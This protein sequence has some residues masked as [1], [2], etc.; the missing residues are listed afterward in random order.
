MRINKKIALFLAL[1]LFLVP[2]YSVTAQSSYFKFNSHNREEFRSLVKQSQENFSKYR[3]AQ[4]AFQEAKN[5]LR[6]MNT[7]RV[8]ALV[9]ERA[10]LFLENALNA[11]ILHLKA[12]KKR[13]EIAQKIK[14]EEKNRILSQIDEQINWF[15]N[16]KQEL[17]GLENREDIKKMAEEMKSYMNQNRVFMKKIIG[18]ILVARMNWVIEAFNEVADKLSAKITALENEGKDVTNLKS[19]LDEF[20][21]KIDEVSN[22]LEQAQNVFEKMEVGNDVKKLFGEGMSY[23]KEAHKGLVDAHKILVEIKVEMNKLSADNNQG[24]A[25]NTNQ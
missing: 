19:K 24:E 2:F 15:E 20:K 11:R 4:K 13:I 5:K 14:E 25:E 17:S 18:Q 1:I 6:E 23:L 7:E 12:L 3:E 22:K 8:Q 9:Q 10:K 21:N 16:K